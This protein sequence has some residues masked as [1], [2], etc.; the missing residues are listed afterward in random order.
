MAFIAGQDENDPNNPQNQP[1]QNPLVSGQGSNNVAQGVSQGG[2]GAGGTGGWTNI[3]A[4][5]KANEGGNGSAQALSNEAK[6]QFDKERNAFQTDSQKFVGDAQNEV[7]SKVI[8][9]KQADDMIKQAGQQYSWGGQQSDDYMKNV[10]KAQ[11]FLNTQYQGPREYNYGFSADTQKYGQAMN[12]NNAFDSVMNR[13]YQNSAGRPLTSGQF[14]L[15]KQFDVNNSALADARKNLAGQ[16]DQL[17][18]DRD[19]TVKNTTDQ[20]KGLEESYTNS[21]NRFRDY[22]GQQ[23]NALDTSVAQQEA[24]ARKAYDQAYKGDS[25]KYGAFNYIYDNS[26]MRELPYS[27]FAAPQTWQNLQQT[28]DIKEGRMP[29]P[30]TAHIYGTSWR[31]IL[32]GGLGFGSVG[33]QARNIYGENQSALND[34]YNQQTAQYA[35]T[36]DA[37]KRGYNSILD[38]L[39]LANSNKKNQGFNVRS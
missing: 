33:A 25:G 39:G 10:N 3:Q 31:D 30:D 17:G 8:D 23:Q 7:N 15:Q 32:T 9:N 14:Q 18:K 13:V 29:V 38:F 26:Y 20:L 2:V 34:F 4:Y 35:D 12:D 11:G 24:D 16:Y 37:E 6:G 28:N 19:T 1:G 36:G 21:Q 22:L 27:W 5:L